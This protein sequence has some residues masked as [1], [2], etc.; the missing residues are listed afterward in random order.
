[1]A[2]KTCKQCGAPLPLQSGRGRP[3]TRCTTC[4]PSAAPKRRTT[5]APVTGDGVL[6]ATRAE[7][8]AAGV[9][10]TSAGQAALSLAAAIDSGEEHGASL[11]ALVK[12]HGATMRAAVPE[13]QPDADPI[14]LLRDELAARREYRAG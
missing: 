11:A 2:V 10:G 13:S 5:T 7:L 6:A 9:A 14:Q 12:Q 8:D 1:L 3:R 4:A